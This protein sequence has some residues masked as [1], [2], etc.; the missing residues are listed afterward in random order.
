MQ[1]TTLSIKSLLGQ[2][3]RT[4]GQKYCSEQ[5]W[6]VVADVEPAWLKQKVRFTNQINLKNKAKELHLL[7]LRAGNFNWPNLID[8]NNK[9]IYHNSLD[10][11]DLWMDIPIHQN[12]N[13]ND[14]QS[15]N[16]RSGF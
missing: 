13:D 4:R 1:R 11:S 10:A 2:L 7:G 15:N 14:K 12:L 16:N 9:A 3:Q 5:T 8:E 6:P